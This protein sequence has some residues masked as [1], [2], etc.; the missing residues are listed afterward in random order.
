MHMY[1][2]IYI[3]IYIYILEREMVRKDM[4]PVVCDMFWSRTSV[5]SLFLS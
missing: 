4:D 5:R 2:Y 3:Y 1:R